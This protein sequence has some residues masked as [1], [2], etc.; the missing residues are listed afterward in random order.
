MAFSECNLERNLDSGKVV[1]AQ[2]RLDSW[3]RGV[4]DGGGE[5]HL[6]SPSWLSNEF[7]VLDSH[8][9]ICPD[10]LVG[11]TQKWSVLTLYLL[12]FQHLSH[13]GVDD[14][15]LRIRYNLIILIHYSSIHCWQL[16]TTS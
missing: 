9:S 12:P 15:A 7:E 2:E 4:N 6:V 13:R 14:T 1:L 3:E 8:D 16:P 11:V 10:I 5:E